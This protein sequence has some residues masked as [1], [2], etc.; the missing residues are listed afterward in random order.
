MNGRTGQCHLFLLLYLLLLRSE[1]KPAPA[2]VSINMMQAANSWNTVCK[3]RDHGCMYDLW[4]HRSKKSENTSANTAS[5][6]SMANEWDIKSND[7]VQIHI[8]PKRE[9]K[10]KVHI[11]WI[12]RSVRFV[13]YIVIRIRIYLIQTGLCRKREFPRYPY[14]LIRDLH[15]SDVTS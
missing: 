5:L 7:R 10:K 11:V 12:A 3:Q 4:T 8:E 2:Q 13:L 1:R 9:G 14:V 15:Q 6:V